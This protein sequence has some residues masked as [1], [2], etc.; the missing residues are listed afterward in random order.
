MFGSQ[1]WLSYGMLS[2]C[3][4]HRPSL[5]WRLSPGGALYRPDIDHVI[6]GL[7]LFVEPLTGFRG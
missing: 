4:R 6:H 5:S 1:V 7:L 2:I 3:R